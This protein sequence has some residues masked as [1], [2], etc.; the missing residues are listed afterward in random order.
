VIQGTWKHVSACNCAHENKDCPERAT[1]SETE[2]ET[3]VSI[4]SDDGEDPGP[5]PACQQQEAS[6]YNAL[7][8]QEQHDEGLHAIFPFT[9]RKLFQSI[10]RKSVQFI[11]DQTEVTESETSFTMPYIVYDEDP[12]PPTRPPASSFLLFRINYIIVMVAIML[13]DGLQGKRLLLGFE[14]FPLRFS[15]N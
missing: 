5:I 11:T 6:F 4:I 14:V 13:A 8:P 9:E 2:T 10:R 12:A 3:D 15:F 7:P 1:D